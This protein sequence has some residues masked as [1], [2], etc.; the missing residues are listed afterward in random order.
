[1]IDLDVGIQ[2]CILYFQAAVRVLDENDTPPRF[3]QNFYREIVKEDVKLASTVA[4]VTVTD[5]DTIGGLQLTI[6]DGNDGI[7]R[8]YPDGE[9]KVL[10][11]NFMWGQISHDCVLKILWDHTAIKSKR[12]GM[13][14]GHS[15]SNFHG[16]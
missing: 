13:K 7:L 12:Q 4:K 5:D 16:D 2:K 9:F 14:Q 10:L 15:D 1:M 3:S 8:I 11:R 6:S